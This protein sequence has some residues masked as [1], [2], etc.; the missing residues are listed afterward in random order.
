MPIIRMRKFPT[1]LRYFYHEDITFCQMP[2]CIYWH[3]C[4]FFSILICLYSELFVDFHSVTIALHIIDLTWLVKCSHFNIFWFNLLIFVKNLWL[5]IGQLYFLWC[6]SPALEF[7]DTNLIKLVGKFS[8]LLYF[9]EK[10]VHNW[11]SLFFKY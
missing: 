5:I 7:S 8:F 10:F 6:I 1:M 4:N 2:L 3:D 11:C 9:L